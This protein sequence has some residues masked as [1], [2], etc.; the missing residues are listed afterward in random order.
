MNLL[1]MKLRRP[2]RAASV[3]TL[4]ASGTSDIAAALMDAIRWLKPMWEELHINI[5]DVPHGADSKMNT[6]HSMNM[7]RP[8]RFTQ[9]GQQEDF[10]FFDRTLIAY[11]I[12]YKVGSNILLRY[13]R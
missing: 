5:T 6:C 7:G 1:L 4:A 9:V 8:S 12:A 2:A 11:C 3:H 13:V 10:G